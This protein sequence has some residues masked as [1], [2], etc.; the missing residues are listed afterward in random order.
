MKNGD[1]ASDEVRFRAASEE[2]AHLLAML[3][4]QTRLETYR[5]IYSDEMLDN[6]D[7]LKNQTVFTE[8]IASGDQQLYL[9]EWKNEVV[10]YFGI[11]KP[12]YWY[13]D[14]ADRNGLFLNAMYL[15]KRFWRHGIGAAAMRFI[16]QKAKEQGKKN[17]YNNCNMHNEN[18]IAFY[19]ACGGNEIFSEGG[20][21]DPAEDQMTFEYL[22]D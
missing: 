8:Q 18:A 12:I 15:L 11:G 2:D 19:K 17:L 7:V 3:R 13:P 1:V 20:H 9:I 22:I 14:N 6:Y 5:G 10:G 21:E 16:R 4:K